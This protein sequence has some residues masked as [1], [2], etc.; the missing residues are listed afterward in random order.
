MCSSHKT[1]KPWE[2]SFR[3]LISIINRN[4]K[5]LE[6]AA[7]VLAALLLWQLLAMAINNR[8]LLVT[9]FVVLERLFR[10]IPTGDFWRSVAFSVSRI[11]SGFLIGSFIGTLLAVIAGRFRI[12][13]ILLRP[14]MA[15]IKATPVASFIILC[16]IWLN[17]RNLSVF[18]SFLMVLPIVYTNVL[19]GIRSTDKQLLEMADLF[20]I[21][22]WRRLRYI[23]IPH[24]TPYILSACTVSIGLSWKAGVAAEVIGIPTG[25]IGERLYEAKVYFSTGD[26]FAWTLVIIA[27]S[28][29]AEKIFVKTLTYLL[30]LRETY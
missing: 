13:D 6:K 20:N 19:L 1:R 8:L 26:L 18:I 7:A 28:I 3:R 22:W 27:L 2:E 5:R 16:L 17:S 4:K 15:A 24:L 9:P 30:N 29:L 12:A 10:M 25:S 21:G 11:L 14:Y 23:Y